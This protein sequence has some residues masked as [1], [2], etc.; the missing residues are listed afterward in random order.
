M[1][2]LAALSSQVGGE[3]ILAVKGVVTARWLYGDPAE[4]PM[5]DVDVR[6]RPSDLAR[7]RR[8][9]IALGWTVRQ[10][11][12]AYGTL[13]IDA[14]GIDVDVETTIGP[15]GLCRLSVDDLLARSQDGAALLGAPCRV[16]ELHDHALVLAVN[17]FKDKL[18]EAF[19]WSREDLRRV[20]QLEAFSPARLVARARESDS[21]TIVSIVAEALGSGRLGEPHREWR[22]VAEALGTHAP[23]PLYRALLGRAMSERPHGMAARLLARWASDCSHE[24][25][26]ALVVAAMYALEQR[27]ERARLSGLGA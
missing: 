14:G 22:A 3:R 21:A 25:R 9:A 10:A 12:R 2:A 15:P 20:A 6:V 24:R 13:Q 19:A 11:S 17:V 1:R 5:A 7:V 23:R 4:R 26:R 8:G 27:L 16:P 18:T